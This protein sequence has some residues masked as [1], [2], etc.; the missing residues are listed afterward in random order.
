LIP[1]NQEYKKAP[2]DATGNGDSKGRADLSVAEE[3]RA[4]LRRSEAVVQSME[5]C[6]WEELMGSGAG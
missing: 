5:D 3:R 1:E 2:D 4:A 6:H